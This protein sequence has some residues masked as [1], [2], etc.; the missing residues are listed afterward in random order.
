MLGSLAHDVDLQAA[1]LAPTIEAL[2]PE[3]DPAIVSPMRALPWAVV[4]P[5]VGLSWLA[6]VNAAVERAFSEH[7][8]AP[9]PE[10][11]T[12]T[13]SSAPRAH[14]TQHKGADHVPAGRDLSAPFLTEEDF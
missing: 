12:P 8:P 14:D 7:V 3:T 6:D 10:R 11:P 1:F 13:T 9:G 4:T 2:T 5:I